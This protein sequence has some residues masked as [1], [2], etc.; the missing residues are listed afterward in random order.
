MVT[1][2]PQIKKVKFPTDYL[3][4]LSAKV[5]IKINRIMK[6]GLESSRLGAI[7]HYRLS[8]DK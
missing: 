1:N 6:V 3:E 2:P 7:S 8:N 4:T 5:S